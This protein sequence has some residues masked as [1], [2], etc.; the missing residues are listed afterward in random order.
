MQ[1]QHTTQTFYVKRKENTVAAGFT[2]CCLS[3]WLTPILSLAGLCCFTTSRAR[4]SLFYSAAGGA[5]LAGIIVFVMY[6][7]V[8]AGRDL[9]FSSDS[10]KYAQEQA[11]Y[12]YIKDDGSFG[13]CEPVTDSFNYTRTWESSRYGLNATNQIVV[14]AN[15]TETNGLCRFYMS[16]ASSQ[17]L[18]YYYELCCVVLIVSGSL[19]L[20][21]TLVYIG[22]G[23]RYMN[24]IK[25]EE[26]NTNLQVVSSK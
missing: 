25:D 24:K 11:G 9:Y 5:L 26:S 3:F 19:Y 7:L 6:S 22:V 23:Y 1:Q 21:T 18:L 2:G 14:P 13:R 17:A 10:F 20:L 8:N 4:S 12:Y 15:A 16:K